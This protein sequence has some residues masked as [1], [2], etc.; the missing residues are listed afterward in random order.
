MME[1]IAMRDLIDNRALVLGASIGLMS[2]LVSSGVDGLFMK[3]SDPKQLRDAVPIVLQGG[4]VI[5]HDVIEKLEH[6][7]GPSVLTTRE[8]QI[9][10]LIATGTSNSRPRISVASAVRCSTSRKVRV[11]MNA[12]TRRKSGIATRKA[13]SRRRRSRF[14]RSVFGRERRKTGF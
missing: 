5:S 6:V 4:K 10:S 3:N 12:P 13:S 2:E 9:L 7:E 11:K 1:T 8:R 14:S